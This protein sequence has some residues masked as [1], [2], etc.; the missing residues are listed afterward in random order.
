MSDTTTGREG[1]TGTCGS[2]PAVPGLQPWPRLAERK[3]ALRGCA[4]A[5][6]RALKSTVRK[7]TETDLREKNP[8]IPYLAA[9][10]ANR[11]LPCS[12]QERQDRMNTEIFERVTDLQYRVDD[13]ELD[14]A[15]PRGGEDDADPGVQQ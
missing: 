8:G 12:V 15:T 7:A 2:E 5:P 10:R 11:D 14:P 4:I 3:T 6:G 1:V 13:L 9:E